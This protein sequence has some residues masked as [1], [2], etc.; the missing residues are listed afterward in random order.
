VLPDQANSDLF[1]PLNGWTPFPLP[2]H[3]QHWLRDRVDGPRRAEVRSCGIDGAG[4]NVVAEEWEQG[5]PSEGLRPAIRES[6]FVIAAYRVHELIDGLDRLRVQA[7]TTPDAR[8]H[9]LA[10]ELSRQGQQAPLAV[11]LV[12]GTREE[13][14]ELLGQAR[15]HLSQRPE[16]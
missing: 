11:A 7:Q 12:A 14:L 5:E 15:A 13:L 16:E 6:L 4:V 1:Y 9:A 10:R 8:L 3:S 2:T